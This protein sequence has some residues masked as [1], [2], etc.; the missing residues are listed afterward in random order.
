MNLLIRRLRLV[1]E[2]F[3]GKFIFYISKFV[4]E[5]IQVS[6]SFI[7]IIIIIFKSLIVLIE[8]V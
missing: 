6:G 1:Y 4:N 2:I 3:V 5:K 7:K 8:S